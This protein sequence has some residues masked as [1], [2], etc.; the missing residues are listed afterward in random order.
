M[1]LSPGSRLGPYEILGVLGA[2]GMGQVFLAMDL[3]LERRV[4]IKV[5]AGGGSI[6]SL[7]DAA[8]K[9]LLREA[10]T[11][12]ALNHPNICVLYE[13]GEADS[14]S[15]IAM[16][17]VEGRTLAEILKNGPLPAA[18]AV[19]YGLQI[20]DAVAHAHDRGFLHRDLKCA[21][22]MVTS[23]GVT[24]GDRI[25]L[26]DFGLA[27]RTPEAA[28]DDVTRS[29]QSE[30]PN[31]MAGTLQYMAPELLRSS[32]PTPASD[33]WALGMVLYQMAAGRLPFA[34]KSI[35][36]MTSAIL[37]ETPPPLPGDTPPALRAV[38]A[39]CLEKEPAQRYGSAAEVRA[40]LET[41]GAPGAFSPPSGL[42]QVS[43]APWS[44]RTRVAAIFA[45]LAICAGVASLLVF[46][47]TP[48]AAPQATP[49]SAQELYLS[50]S[51]Y[52]ARMNAEDNRKAIEL[53]E[54]AVA[55][56]PSMAPAWGQL[57]YSYA[58]RP[59]FVPDEKDT[60]QKAYVAIQ[61]ALALDPK[62]PEAH[63]ALAN[64]LWTAQQHFASA[65]AIQ[66]CRRAISAAPNS[67]GAHELLATIYVHSGLFKEAI[68][69][70]LR[71]RQ[72]DPTD[73]Q[74]LVTVAEAQSD[75][76]NFQAA[77]ETLDGVPRQSEPIVPTRLAWCRLKLGQ[78]AEAAKI[79]DDAMGEHVNDA[80]GMFISA[81][82]VVFAAAG[83]VPHADEAIAAALAQA[84]SYTHLHHQTAFHLACAYALLKRPAEAVEAL[85]SAAKN[86]L[87]N[88]PLFASDSFLAGIKA[89]RDFQAFLKELSG[90]HAA[91]KAA[92]DA[93]LP[94]LP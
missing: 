94:A 70:A 86:G 18:S 22:I 73:I 17:H 47:R 51:Y 72:L 38:I 6:D 21:N 68:A 9:R 24:S 81:R 30:N 57:A 42:T 59:L 34:G 10:R 64:Y 29:M 49:Q 58:Q 61:R 84:K 79:L 19:R 23:G 33:L 67:A 48:P 92:V 8:Q 1:H 27:C 93:P 87:P 46:H 76:G 25:K 56:D 89:D 78:G 53:L 20:A 60:E 7:D 13:A 88:Y 35:F 52:A 28:L 3:K 83:D 2:G 39:R 16:E 65:D 71:T 77:L 91:L 32:P 63:R 26:L 5:L 66:E 50:G 11:A 45:V 36:E 44:T 55:R 43:P 31:A 40:V 12:S 41:V 4:A 85:R 75:E 62:S 80:A 37:N 90:K 54:Q 15:Y 74:A 82:A 14:L 69:E